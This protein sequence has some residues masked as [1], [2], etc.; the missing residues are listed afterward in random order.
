VTG[1]R[2]TLRQVLRALVC[3]ALLALVL[4]GCGGISAS[5]A[6]HT[7]ID[8]VP[9]VPGDLDESGTPDIGALQVN[10]SW[11]SE[12][13]RPRGVTPGP[14]ATLPSADAVVPY[15][16]TSWQAS[17]NGDYT[18]QLRHGVR[19]ST[20]D[21][22]TASDVQWSIERALA[23]SPIAPFLLKL[24]NVDTRDPVTVL[25]PFTVRIN[26]TAPS[27]FLLGVLSLYDEGI[28]DRRAYLAHATPGDPWGEQWGAT[29]S[30]SFGAYSVQSFT[31][32]KT[33]VLVANPGSWV[34][35]YYTTIDINSV[36]NPGTRLADLLHGK[37]D[38]TSGL[39]WANFT[40]AEQ[41]GSV[42]HVSA[43]ILQT[44]PQIESW[45]LGVHK[46]PL[47]NPLVREAISA[48]VNRGELSDVLY[49]GFATPDVLS[50]PAIYGQRQPPG[51]NQPRARRLLAQ[52]GYRHGLTINVDVPLNIGGGSESTE[53]TTIINQ[54]LQ[55]G[56]TLVPTVVSDSDQ[57]L[58]LAQAHQVD[59]TI[60]D[61]SPL[62][63][64]AEFLLLQDDAATLDSVS[65]AAEEGYA[66]P[67][68]TALLTKLRDTPPGPRAEQLTARAA[69][70]VDADTPA[71]N[72]FEVPVQNITRSAITGYDAYAVPVTY[73]ESLHPTR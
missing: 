64:G 29:H 41:Y 63:S 2:P 65:P 8:E 45:L 19:G 49:A 54:L 17:P 32:Y 47:A 4:G 73:Y 40:Y 72:L 46:G 50:I 62:L 35:P 48:A 30:A 21:P 7:F 9:S 5:A 11:S 18:F 33:I 16:A 42:N 37:A 3:A 13:V 31:Q 15:L 1:A 10:S 57:L 69:K 36:A 12:L 43:T 51:L 25:G 68:V 38:H 59:S 52:A 66:N 27:P 6:R 28:Y 44:G 14:N 39:E 61:I 53:L 58:A 55:V 22:F 67:T 24:A 71:V 60:E 70:L 20:G 23:T 34:H 26:V 56:I